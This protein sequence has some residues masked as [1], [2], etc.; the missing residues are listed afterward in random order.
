M[1]AGEK[2][3]K[4]DCSNLDISKTEFSTGLT[5]LVLV[6]CT[7]K[8]L[9]FDLGLGVCWKLKTCLTFGT[10]NWAVRY[11]HDFCIVFIVYPT[12]IISLDLI[13]KC[14]IWIDVSGRPRTPKAWLKDGSCQS[15]ARKHCWKISRD[16]L[17]NL[18]RLYLWPLDTVW[19][20][21]FF[22]ILRKAPA[23][24]EVIFIDQKT[25]VEFGVEHL[26]K[27]ARNC[28]TKLLYIS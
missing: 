16:Q 19:I 2:I 4:N 9:I 15:F 3:K 13:V 20:R 22:E 8:S 23:L 28:I 18:N 27:S 12:Q 6:R 21:F 26:A 1:M 5:M 14:H 7:I 10:I 11:T 24:T 25:K 17:H